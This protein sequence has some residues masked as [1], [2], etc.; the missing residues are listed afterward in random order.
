MTRIEDALGVV[1]RG[2][3]VPGLLVYGIGEPG[4]HTGLP[5][6][7]GSGWVEVGRWVLV[8]EHAH[9]VVVT[10]AVTDMGELR[11]AWPAPLDRASDVLLAHGA[12]ACWWMLEAAAYADPPALFDPAET[13]GV[14]GW[15]TRQEGTGWPGLDDPATDVPPESLLRLRSLTAGLS[16]RD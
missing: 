13:G 11:R 12:V 3:E 2:E 9:V 15:V 4:W 7:E 16:D 8:T 6:V 14:L 1:F 10:L 5:P